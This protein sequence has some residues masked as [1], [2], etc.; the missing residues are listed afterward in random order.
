MLRPRVTYRLNRPLLPM[1]KSPNALDLNASDAS[2]AHYGRAT[3]RSPERV[4]TLEPVRRIGRLGVR[5][6]RSV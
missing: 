5:R 4:K 2:G 6:A 1:A 3:R